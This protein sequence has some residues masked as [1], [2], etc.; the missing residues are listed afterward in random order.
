MGDS[1]VQDGVVTVK[2]MVCKWCLG[3]YSISLAKAVAI[4][5]I[6][7]QLLLF[8]ICHASGTYSVKFARFCFILFLG[9]F[10]AND[11][12]VIYVRY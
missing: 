1:V 12:S 4:D 9:V 3:C 11:Q 5:T 6:V 8:R 2:V 10:R 7:T